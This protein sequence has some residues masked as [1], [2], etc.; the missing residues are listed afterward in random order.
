MVNTKERVLVLAAHP[1]DEVLGCGGAIARHREEGDEVR[2]LIMGE[3][4]AARA[5]ISDAEVARQQEALR[6]HIARA[7]AVLGTTGYSQLTLPDQ[8]FDT[9]PLLDITHAVEE[10]IRS[11]NPTLIYTHHAGD[12]NLDHTTLARAVEAAVRPGAHASLAEVRAFEVPSSSEWNFTRERFAPQVFVSLTESQLKKKIDAMRAYESE[13]RPFPHPRSP[14][15][16]DALARVRGGQ[17]GTPAAEA[18]AAV[19]RRI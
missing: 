15:Y 16:L 1:D 13:M 6:A 2:V 7:N 4:I 17:S 8:R 14:E 5:G 11:C 10:A 18:F 12:V 3:G 9:M 19:Y